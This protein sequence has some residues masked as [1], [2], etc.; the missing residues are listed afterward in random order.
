MV[1]MKW[2]KKQKYYAH[3]DAEGDDDDA[4][5]LCGTQQKHPNKLSTC[6][7]VV[8]L[9][10]Q[11]QCV[12]GQFLF[13]NS[14]CRRYFGSHRR[15]FF[16]NH[17]HF[18]TEWKLKKPHAVSPITPD[19]IHSFIR[20]NAATTSRQQQ[21]DNEKYIYTFHRYSASGLALAWHAWS[22][23][24]DVPFSFPS[25]SSAQRYR[26]RFHLIYLYVS[27]GDIDACRTDLR[28]N[29]E[30]DFSIGSPLTQ[31]LLLSKKRSAKN[32]YRFQFPFQTVPSGHTL[33]RDRAEEKKRK[34]M[35]GIEAQN[36][37]H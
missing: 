30:L 24:L 13:R 1:R 14:C 15:T 27:I 21:I 37:S 10:G 16:Q 29:D 36:K 5:K 35:R 25:N 8:F 18:R 22:L 31:T 2:R 3:T 17:F 7:C 28:F 6:P 23:H 33:H 9:S 4:A 12:P 20:N 19:T 34:M 26:F 32:A 11:R